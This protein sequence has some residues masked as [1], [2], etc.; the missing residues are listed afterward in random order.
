MSRSVRLYTAAQFEEVKTLVD[1]MAERPT[2]RPPNATSSQPSRRTLQQTVR[3]DRR[4]ATGTAR[5]PVAADLIPHA[6]E[7][8][9]ATGHTATYPGPADQVHHVRRA[10]ARHLAGCPAA[11]EAVLIVSELAANAIVHSAEP[12]R[13]LHRPRR[14][15]RGLRPDRGRRPRRPLAPQAAR[16][17]PARPGPGG[18]PH[19]PGRLGRRDHHRRRPDRLGTP[20]PARGGGMSQ[21]VTALGPPWPRR[22]TPTDH[23]AQRR[24]DCPVC[25][26]RGSRDVSDV[27]RRQAASVNVPAR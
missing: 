24:H 1:L 3:E 21:H 2:C 25:D 8:A 19:R 6:A 12:G 17:P 9:A 4:R 5:L 27:S 14:T 26:A 23:A 7:P 13:V 10:V 22:G 20:R 18:S 15:A 16:R 11:D